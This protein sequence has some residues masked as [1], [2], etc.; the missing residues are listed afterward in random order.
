MAA[1]YTCAGCISDASSKSEGVTQNVHGAFTVA[2]VS[3]QRRHKSNECH[4]HLMNVAA[5]MQSFLT[6]TFPNSHIT[7]DCDSLPE[8]R[9]HRGGHLRVLTHA[10]QVTF[11]QGL[12][13]SDTWE[14]RPTSR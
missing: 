3:T 4:S 11:A 1:G 8:A 9:G 13:I 10:V 5:H 7:S 12:K 2:V 14:N 6:E